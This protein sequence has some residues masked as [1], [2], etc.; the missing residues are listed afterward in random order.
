MNNRIPRNEWLPFPLQFFVTRTYMRLNGSLHSVSVTQT[1]NGMLFT[2]ITTKVYIILLWKP[3]EMRSHG[4]RKRRLQ[5][6]RQTNT[7][8]NPISLPATWNVEFLLPWGHQP[9]SFALLEE[10]ESNVLCPSR[11]YCNCDVVLHRHAERIYNFEIQWGEIMSKNGK[12]FWG[13]HKYCRHGERGTAMA[14]SEV[15]KST[16]QLPFPRSHH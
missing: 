5:W 13:I 16:L 6:V 2:L 15:I 7:F 14:M 11:H 4:R 9:K 10:K 3:V 1:H 8:Q 12:R